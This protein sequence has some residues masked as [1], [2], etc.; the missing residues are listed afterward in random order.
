MVESCQNKPTGTSLKV[1]YPIDSVVLTTAERVV[2]PDSVPSVAAKIFPYELTK[3]AQNGFGKWHFG[4]GL[5]YEKRV[6]LMPAG[7]VSG[8]G[9]GSLKL[10]KFFTMTDIH[11]TD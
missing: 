11:I 6:D 9:D 3:Y 1:S 2:V 4:K 7:Y 5:P 10:L 8:G